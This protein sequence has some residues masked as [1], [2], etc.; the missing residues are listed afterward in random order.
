MSE[1]T[2][3]ETAAGYRYTIPAPF[4]ECDECGSDDTS[5]S[6]PSDRFGGVV[7]F[8]CYACGYVDVA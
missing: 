4:R 8:E 7:Q 2:I 1:T 6:T 3:H 5:T